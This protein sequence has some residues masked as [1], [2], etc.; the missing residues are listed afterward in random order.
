MMVSRCVVT[1]LQGKQPFRTLG[2]RVMCDSFFIVRTN[3]FRTHNVNIRFPHLESALWLWCQYVMSNNGPLHDE[4]ITSRAAS[5]ARTMGI[6]EDHFRASARWL[7][8]FKHRHGLHQITLHG[9]AADV[10]TSCLAGQR[11]RLRSLIATYP[12]DNVYNADETALFW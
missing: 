9:E 3:F 4:L 11:Q 10:D 2:R 7:E 6:H 12:A 8:R 1:G 5:L